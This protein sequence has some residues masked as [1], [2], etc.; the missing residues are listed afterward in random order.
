MRVCTLASG[1]SGNS[2]YIE[3]G[4]TK[5]LVDAG[6]SLRQLGLRLAKLGVGI[7]D[8][9]AVVVTHEHSDHTTALPMTGLPTYIASATVHLWKDKVRSIMEFES[10]SPF[11]IKD[12]LVTPFSVPH[13]ALD[14]VGFTIES[15]DGLK[16]GLV[17]D[18]GSV[19]TLVRERL[20]GSNALV[21]EFNHDSDILLY[22]HYPWDLKQRIKGR[23]GHLSNNQG[24]ELLSELVHHGLKHVVLAHL[25]QVN[26][27]PEVA[28]ES[29]FR[30]VRRH[31]GERDVRISVAPRKTAGEVLEFDR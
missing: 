30:V 8:I 14:P 7:S 29:A 6:I 25:S 16:I 24:A 11:Q 22:S 4:G 19:T 10:D 1:S 21:I 15:G 23:L 2:L 28:Y 9:D 3:C 17:T 26:N 5:I 12:F 27:R 31:G 13:D 18:I 20:R